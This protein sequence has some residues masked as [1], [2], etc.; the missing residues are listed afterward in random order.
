MS[1]ASRREF[2][3]DVGRGMLVASMGPALSA[4]LGFSPAWAAEEAPRLT[5]GKQEPLVTLMQETAPD[6]LLPALVERLQKGTELGELVAAAALANARTFGGEDYIGFHTLMALAPAYAMSGELPAERRPLPILK[7][8]YRNSNRIKEKGGTRN[9]VLKPVEAVKIPEGKRGDESVRDSVRRK[10]LQEAE[11]YYASVAGSADD[12]LNNVLPTVFDGADVHRVVLVSRAWDLLGLVGKERAHTLLR[13][14]VH[15]CIRSENSGKYAEYFAP[16]RTL[17]PKLLDRYHLPGKTPGSR[18]VDDAWVEKMMETV[19]TGTPEQAAD[20]VAAALGE[21]IAPAA[22]GEAISLGAN[23]LVLRDNGR[24]AREAQPNKPVGS[25]HGDGIGVHACDSTNAWRNLSRV[26]SPTSAVSCLILAAYQLA[27]D[28]PGRGGDFLKWE[29]YPRAD[30][31]ERVKDKEPDRLLKIAED[32]IRHNEQALACAAVARY[33]QEGHPERPVFDLLLRYA[34]SEDGALHA[35]KF[36]RTVTEEFS[37]A[38]PAFRWR[39][40]VALARVTASEYGQPA[41]GYADA[42]RLLKL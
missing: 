10:Q 3:A 18:V 37:S 23:Q 32:A 17:L 5:F 6:K 26:S 42:C 29:A 12:A 24:T 34:V 20:A 11:A 1:R 30:A 27:V 7:V 22:I 16:M 14:S 36:Y 41:P 33:G 2:L 4:D 38:R 31:R 9:E 40:L 39:H 13:Q 28:R 15:F 35:E 8:L 21:G 19:F 25:V